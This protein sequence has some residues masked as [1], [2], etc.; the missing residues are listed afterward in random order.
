MLAI[1][2]FPSPTDL[3]LWGG[4]AATYFTGYLIMELNNRNALLRIRSRMMSSTFLI[5]M[6][7]CPSL[8][9][10]T[11]DFLPTMCLILAYFML[12]ASYQQTR[13]EGYIY[14]S[15]LFLSVGSII[16]PPMLVL[17]LAYYFSMLFQLRN[18]TGRSMMAGLLGLLTPYWIY[19][20]YAIWNNQLDTAFTYLYQWFEPHIP[21]YQLLSTAEWITLGVVVFYTFI[22]FVHFFHTA[23]NDK[24]RT[25]MLF[26]VIATVQVFLTIGVVLLPDSFDLQMRLFIANSSLLIAHYLSLGKGRFFHAWFNLTLI[27]F[28]ALGTFNYLLKAGA[29][30]L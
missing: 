3:Y 19:A 28:A 10:W 27:I 26:Y 4:L 17:A 12:F 6:S 18:L 30:A 29:F 22:S 2:I 20:A 7:V 14:H 16:F 23:Y 1:W 24:I 25:R 15:F 11:T 9:T 21:N 13:P 5:L 8:H